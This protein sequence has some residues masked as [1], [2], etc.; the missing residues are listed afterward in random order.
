MRFPKERKHNYKYNMMTFGKG[1]Y[2][3]KENLN[4]CHNCPEINP[5]F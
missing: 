2:S 1:Q 5:G 3:G 4:L